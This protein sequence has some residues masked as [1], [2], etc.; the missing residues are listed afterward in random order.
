MFSPFPARTADW[1]IC[2]A[3]R[4]WG[5]RIRQ[6]EFDCKRSAT[7]EN[8]TRLPYKRMSCVTVCV[9]FHSY[10]DV[11]ITDEGLQILTYT[12]HSWPMSSEG[13]W[14]CSTYCDGHL[15][16]PVTL[17]PIAE[18]LAWELIHVYYLFLRLRSVVDWIRTPNL[19]LVGR[20]L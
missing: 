13:S 3:F 8:V 4:R 18:R 16:G 17:T 2:P 12:R 19:R 11:T 10:G 9:I 6:W 7:D 1:S 14:A 15:R 20:T 5:F